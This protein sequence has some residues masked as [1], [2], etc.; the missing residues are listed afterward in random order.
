M[1]PVP[2]KPCVSLRALMGSP[3]P[4]Q[5]VGPTAFASLKAES[6]WGNHLDRR[7]KNATISNCED[8]QRVGLLDVSP[9][10]ASLCPLPLMTP[11]FG[12]LHSVH[13]VPGKAS[14][15]FVKAICFCCTENIS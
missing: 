14:V 8:S 3:S 1:V 6:V 12:L 15:T 4:T 10:A 5:A 7:L 11:A 2:S 13:S 9:V